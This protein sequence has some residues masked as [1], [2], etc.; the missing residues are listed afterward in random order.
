M[1]IVIPTPDEVAAMDKRQRDAWRKRM[2]LVQRQV[3][4][5]AT[6]LTYGESVVTQA[7][8]WFDIYGPD[9]DAAQHQAELLEWV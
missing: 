1:P 9:P 7:R 5:S 8:L 4:Q 6:L 3:A 2:G